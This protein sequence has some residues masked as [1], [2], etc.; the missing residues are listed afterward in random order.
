[1]PSPVFGLVPLLP[2]R[3]G[4]LNLLEVKAEHRASIPGDETRLDGSS[5][6]ERVHGPDTSST[7]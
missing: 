3:P 2:P 5:E 6:T 7:V 1:V 4:G